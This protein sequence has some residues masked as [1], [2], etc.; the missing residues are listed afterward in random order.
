MI[1]NRL[2]VFAFYHAE[3]KVEDY[4]LCLLDSMMKLLGRLVMVVNGSLSDEGMEKLQRYSGDIY[5][6]ENFGF[7]GEAYRD[8]MTKYLKQDDINQYDQCVLF[9]NTFCG[10]FYDWSILFTQMEHARKDFWGLS[11]W[12]GGYSSLLGEYVPEHVQAYF[13]VV[14]KSMLHSSAFMDFWKNMAV[15]E[16]YEDAIRNFEAGFTQYFLKRGFQYLTWI[17]LTGGKVLLKESEVVYMRHAGELIDTY[18]FPV[19]KRKACSISNIDQILRIK[20]YLEQYKQVDHRIVHDFI[21]GVLKGNEKISLSE[22]EDFY[23]DHRKIY[24]YGNG[25]WAHKLKLYFEFMDWKE[26]AFIVSKKTP[27]EEVLEYK[28]VSFENG[29]GV[30]IAVGEKYS[31]EIYEG[32]RK[33]WTNL[34]IFL[35]IR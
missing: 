24:I 6:R 21:E 11:K 30:I 27:E 8:I 26:E 32:L 19:L 23:K 28:D 17:D 33:E 7:D 13:V 20:R 10:P 12:I 35:L 25:K 15:I 3:G 34:D 9:N 14:E 5:F 16:C 18:S 22:I 4:I 29:D 2:G 31:G 1:K